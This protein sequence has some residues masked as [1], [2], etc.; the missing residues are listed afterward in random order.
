MQGKE[1]KVQSA[2]ATVLSVFINTSVLDF[3]YPHLE[4]FT[5]S[6]NVNKG[7]QITFHSHVV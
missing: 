5:V 4:A 7:V 6:E 3:C 2:A 1:P